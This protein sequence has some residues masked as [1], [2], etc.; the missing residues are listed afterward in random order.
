VTRKRKHQPATLEQ[1]NT[2]ERLMA[3]G[4]TS[5]ASARLTA[6]AKPIGQSDNVLNRMFSRGWVGRTPE[7]RMWWLTEAGA[8]ALARPATPYLEAAE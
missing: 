5:R 3:L 1:R 7:P 6:Q 8:E 4:A 2:M